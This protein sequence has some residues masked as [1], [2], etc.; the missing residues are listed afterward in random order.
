LST[1]YLCAE[2]GGIDKL[3]WTLRYL[4]I[5]GFKAK[6]TDPFSPTASAREP[7]WPGG[8]QSLFPTEQDL[9]Q[10]KAIRAL[11]F[12]GGF[13]DFTKILARGTAALATV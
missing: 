7:K 3:A 4:P 1:H 10:K 11:C 2:A 12:L 5:P 9:Q 6:P 13:N 8:K